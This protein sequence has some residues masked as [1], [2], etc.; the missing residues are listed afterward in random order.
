MKRVA[1]LLALGA[2]ILVLLR[3]ARLSR[4]LTA[5][6]DTQAAGDFGAIINDRRAA[7]SSSWTH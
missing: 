5:H 6:D 3:A 4:S 2:C 1:V 7:G